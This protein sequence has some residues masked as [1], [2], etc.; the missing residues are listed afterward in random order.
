MTTPKNKI[1]L[2]TGGS[3]GLGKDMA[4]RVAEN[5]LDVIITYNKNAE[6]AARVV[7]LINENGTK[8]AALQLN[9]GDIKSFGAFSEQLQQT[10]AKDFN[11]GYFDFLVNNAGIGG[12]QLIADVTEDF[13]DEL[14]NIH[15]KGVYFL[16]QQLLPLINDGGG[17]VNVSSGL[18]RV[19]L[20]KSSAYASM[21]GA[22]EVFTRYVA[23]EF[24]TRGIR[25]NTIAPGA[26]MTDFGNG[27]LRS[28]EESQK[29]VSSVTALGRPGVAEDIGGV[30]AFLCSEEAR[31]VNGQRIEI[32]GGMLI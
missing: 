11:T 2:I 14:Y 9:T 19:S 22:V 16:T 13:F 25:A 7:A 10:L 8:A 32:S 23:K 15:F 24:G 5:G 20:P 28:S 18:T 6:E 29:M 21:K 17:I 26:I 30:V 12:Y 4:L 3:R 31:W 1:A 27:H